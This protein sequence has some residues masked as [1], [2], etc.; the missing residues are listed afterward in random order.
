MKFDPFGIGSLSVTQR[1]EH[2]RK[3]QREIDLYY[4]PGSDFPTRPVCP[5]ISKNELK[6]LTLLQ[7]ALPKHYIFTQ[8]QLTRLVDVDQSAIDDYNNQ[9]GGASKITKWQFLNLFQLLSVD[10]AICDSLGLPV[11]AIELDGPEHETDPDKGKR[12]V[13]KARA[14]G[15]A[16]IALCRFYNSQLT[17]VSGCESIISKVVSLALVL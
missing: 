13:I 8:V 7:A 14:L 10:F 3:L 1:A 4:A 12:D 9:N 2:E 5:F 15:G 6:L 17:S 11:C 16:G